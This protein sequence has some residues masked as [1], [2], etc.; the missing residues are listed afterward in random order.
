MPQK[1][2][3]TPLERAALGAMFG[4]LLG[5]FLLGIGAIRLIIALV[6]GAPISD[7]GYGVNQVLTLLTVYCGSFA[8]AGAAMAALWPLRESWLGSYLLGYLGAGIVSVILGRLIMWLEHDHDL[9]TFVITACIMTV[10][11]GT[12]A[13]YKIHHWDSV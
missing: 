2:Q 11:F 7:D 8:V 6:S 3:R 5:V 9:W 13:G 4:G 1:V 12:F 10:V